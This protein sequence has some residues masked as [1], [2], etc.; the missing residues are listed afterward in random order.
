VISFTIEGLRLANTSNL[1]E[2]WSQTARRAADQRMIVTAHARK[3][4]H[5]AS[6]AAPLRITVVRIG[7]GKMDRSN[8]YV[9]SKHVEDALSALLGVDDGDEANWLLVCKQERPPKGASY[10]YAV[11]IEIESSAEVAS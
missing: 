11:R 5:G 4:I 6:I 10:K 2:H 9:T 1:R 7:P 8:L 3:A